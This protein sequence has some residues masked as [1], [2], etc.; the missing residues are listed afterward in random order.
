MARHGA[1]AWNRR[2]GTQIAEGRITP[3]DPRTA[4][5]RQAEQDLLEAS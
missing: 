1:E 5:R 2:C 3:R 4:A